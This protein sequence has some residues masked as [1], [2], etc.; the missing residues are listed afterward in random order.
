MSMPFIQRNYVKYH[1]GKGMI[2]GHVEALHAASPYADLFTDKIVENII[3]QTGCAGIISTVSRRHIDLNRIP[4][5]YNAGG[6]KEYRTTIDN[7]LEFLDLISHDSNH[8]KKPYLHLSFHGM[9]DVHHGPYAIEVG[10]IH[11]QSCSSEI[12]KWFE[13]ILKEKAHEKI[14]KLSVV[15][16]QK[17]IGD[18]SI[19]LHRLGDGGS[20]PGYGPNFH[21]FQLELSH[22]VRSE[23]C[24]Q[25]SEL[26][27]QIITE[28]QRKFVHS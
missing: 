2:S 25:I 24:P 15:L 22:T 20:Y 5:R 14:P 9:K 12:R 21:T 6:I 13:E 4:N 16:D 26:F 27:S 18:K 8:L 17:F 7:I 28:F 10:T 19:V 23:L 3:K 1:E 11:G